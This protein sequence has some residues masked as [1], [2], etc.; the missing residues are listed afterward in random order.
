MICSKYV[1]SCSHGNISYSF[2][3]QIQSQKIKQYTQ[4]HCAASQFVL[5][6]TVVVQKYEKY[7]EKS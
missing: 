7:F 5:T 2:F 3:V 4:K 6:D 1:F